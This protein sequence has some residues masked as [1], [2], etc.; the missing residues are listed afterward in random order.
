MRPAD[1]ERGGTQLQIDTG[2]ATPK[3]QPPRRMPFAVRGEVEGVSL[4]A[5]GSVL[6]SWSVS[7]V[8]STGSVSI[9]VY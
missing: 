5:P 6:L 4:K 9:T 3:R 2:E 7:K 8:T 1:G